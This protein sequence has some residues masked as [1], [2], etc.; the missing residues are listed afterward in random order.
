MNHSKLH[1]PSMVPNKVRK[2]LNLAYDAL[3]TILS[4]LSS[5]VE[6]E[7]AFSAAGMIIMKLR[8]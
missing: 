4:R 8:T 6:S 7:K 2:S 3:L 1:R 5:S